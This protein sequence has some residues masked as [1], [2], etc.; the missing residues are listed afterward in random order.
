MPG[1]NTPCRFWCYSSWRKACIPRF[2]ILSP[3]SRGPKSMHS[4]ISH[5]FT[6]FYV[7]NGPKS[8]SDSMT[9]MGQPSGL[10]LIS[11]PSSQPG[12]GK[13]STATEPMDRNPSPRIHS[14]GAPRDQGTRTLSWQMTR[15][16]DANAGFS[17]M[18]SQRRHC[19]VRRTS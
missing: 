4:P 19:A 18:S 13:P 6:T 10:H 8:S 9:N 11:C 15:T 1:I 2:S 3:K 16:T 14:P 12:H 7:G 17:H 5:T